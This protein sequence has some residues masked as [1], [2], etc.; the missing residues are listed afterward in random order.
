MDRSTA[1]IKSILALSIAPLWISHVS[2]ESFSF[3]SFGGQ[4]SFAIP[5]N[6][7]TG[8]SDS[9]NISSSITSIGS[10]TVSLDISGPG[11]AFN[12]DFYVYLQHDSGLAVLLNRPGKSSSS[13]SDFGYSDNGFNIQLNDSAVNGDIHVYQTKVVPQSGQQL[14]GLWQ[15]DGRITDPDSVATSDPRSNLLSVFNGADANGTW[16]LFISDNSDQGI[17]QLN[18]W[19]LDFAP[20]PEPEEWAAISGVGLLGF[21]IWRRSKRNST[22]VPTI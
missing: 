17:G 19:G 10:I 18:S 7:G 12:G 4:S 11:G 14:T 22:A 3:N 20:V 1:M 13:S 8:V 2:A 15:P 9:R 6:L 16:K 5:D 21:A